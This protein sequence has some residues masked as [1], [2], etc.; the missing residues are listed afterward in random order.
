MQSLANQRAAQCEQAHSSGH[1]GALRRTQSAILARASCALELRRVEKLSLRLGADPVH[2]ARPN[3][4]AS[5]QRARNL[6]QKGVADADGQPAPRPPIQQTPDL[7]APPRAR[8]T[9]L[10]S[11][12]S[13]PKTHQQPPVSQH[14]ASYGPSS[15]GWQQ[16][17]RIRRARGLSCDWRADVRR[18][19]CICALQVS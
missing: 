19:S 14:G 4:T 12:D 17:T 7:P 8:P 2:D 3:L 1:Q 5:L 9:R 10:G 11:S 15:V 13:L 16:D 18:P 6:L